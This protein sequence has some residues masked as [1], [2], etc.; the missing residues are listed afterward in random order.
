MTELMYGIPLNMMPMSFQTAHRVGSSS[1]IPVHDPPTES[2]RVT[3]LPPLNM[4]TNEAATFNL[5]VNRHVGE[6]IE[7]VSKAG[8]LGFLKGE[9]SG[10]GKQKAFVQAKRKEEVSFI[11]VPRPQEQYYQTY[12]QAPIEAI[13]QDIPKPFRGIDE[14]GQ[15]DG[16]EFCIHY[17]QW[18][19]SL[20]K[21]QEFRCLVQ[22]LMNLGVVN[23]EKRSIT[24]EKEVAMM[25]KEDKGF[26]AFVLKVPNPP[27]ESI[28]PKVIMKVSAPFLYQSNH[29][30][31][32]NYEVKVELVKGKPEDQ[33]ACKKDDSVTNVGAT[34]G[35]TRSGR[36]YL[37]DDTQKQKKETKG[38]L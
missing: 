11:I 20:E 2:L 27:P 6:R 22:K 26:H 10:S 9:S 30:V 34:G 8:K 38:S 21:C 19:H 36:Y 29:V 31:P 5:N 17:E 12:P 24:I 15:Y 3:I 32:W 35:F 4:A 7:V 14:D 16:E 1:S 13:G 33:E 18:G 28:T 23:V 25:R 37:P